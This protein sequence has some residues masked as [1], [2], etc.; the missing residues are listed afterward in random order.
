[1]TLP[2]GATAVRSRSQLDARTRTDD[3]PTAT[4]ASRELTDRW[5]TTHAELLIREQGPDRRAAYLLRWSPDGLVFGPY[6]DPDRSVPWALLPA[7]AAVRA[8]WSVLEL[9]PRTPSSPHVPEHAAGP[10]TAA[11]P[12]RELRTDLA[13]PGLDDPVTAAWL[14]DGSGVW[15][16]RG[17]GDGPVERVP[18]RPLEVLRTLSAWDAAIARGLGAGGGPPL[19]QGTDTWPVEVAGTTVTLAAPTRWHPLD[20]AGAHDSHVV[21]LRE[22]FPA[23]VVNR[24]TLAQEVVRAPVA[25]VRDAL[26]AGLDAAHAIDER[27]L[28]DGVEV[29]ILHHDPAGDALLLQRQ[30]DIATS[31]R[32]VLSATCP[33][34][35]AA[36]HLPRLIE[37]LDRT[38]IDRR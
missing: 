36:E 34:A 11:A 23:G 20:P 9:G 3:D 33:I 28:V 8:M 22:P 7:D 38:T 30:R 15:E 17:D 5:T 35:D 18:T 24:L 2:S 32:V 37:L 13:L 6:D 25:A 16:L 14:S 12:A 19:H 4:A 21:T 31:G 10:D 29:A 26:L 1:M 27:T